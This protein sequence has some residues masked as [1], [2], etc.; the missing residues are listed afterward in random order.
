MSFP[1]RR[2]QSVYLEWFHRSVAARC[3]RTSRSSPT[4]PARSTCSTA[5][6][7]VSGSCSTARMRSA[8]GRRRRDGARP[9]RRPARRHRAPSSPRSPTTTASRSCRADT[10]PSRTSRCSRPAPTCSS[11][12]SGR[13]SPTS[14]PSS[15][16]AAAVASS[17]HPTARLI[18]EPSGLEPVLHVGSRRGVPYR[19]KLTYRLQAPLAPLPRFLDDATIAALLASREP[20]DFFADVLPLVAKEIGW[21]YYHELF[22]AHPG[23]HDDDAG[24]SSLRDTSRREMGHRARPR[25][26]TRR[27]CPTAPTASTSP[28][29]TSRLP[30][31]RSRSATRCTATSPHHVAADVARRTDPAYSADLAAFTAML[32][33]AEALR[34]IAPRVTPTVAA[35]GHQHVVAQLLHVLRQWSAAGAAAPAARARRRRARALRRRRH[36]RRRRRRDRDVRRHEQRAIPTRSAATALIDA[37]IA[38]PSVSRSTSVLLRTTSH[39]AARSSRTS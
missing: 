21:A 26:L 11:S 7:A 34:R 16:R 23:A 35:R 9:P 38:R 33:M 36:D 24:T 29:S 10:P 12:A 2:V 13:R 3:R 27:P 6:T 14:S 8:A 15:P 20:L 17:R 18:Y 4:A 22:V 28:R 19:S 37:R 32:G 39:A 31:S 5:T 25:S 1:T 30:A